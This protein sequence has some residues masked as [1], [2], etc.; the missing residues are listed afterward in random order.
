MDQ[1]RSAGH[2]GLL[3]LF[4][5]MMTISVFLFAVGP[6]TT[7]GKV[8]VFVAPWSTPHRV[9]D[10]IANADGSFVGMGTNPWIAI[11]ISQ[12][13]DFVSRLYQAG[14]FYVG[15][16]EVFSACLPS[17]FLRANRS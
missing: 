6:R 2:Y 15:S 1:Q 17:S 9:M 14:A 7:G 3:G 8:V 12:S 13:S 4:F 10:V 5:L 11:G 16:A